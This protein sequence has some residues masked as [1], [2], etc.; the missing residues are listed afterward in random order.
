MSCDSGSF[1]SLL[2]QIVFLTLC[3]GCHPIAS[4]QSWE[5]SSPSGLHET[6]GAEEAFLYCWMVVGVLSPNVV[7]TDTM[8]G[9]LCYQW[10]MR[11][12]LTLHQEILLIPV[13]MGKMGIPC[14]RQVDVEGLTHSLAQCGRGLVIAW[15]SSWLSTP[16]GGVGMPHYNCARMKVQTSHFTS[17]Y[18]C[19]HGWWWGHSIFCHIWLD[20][21][22]IV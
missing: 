9:C 10:V 1:S 13:P 19:Q 16:G 5:S 2:V 22:V 11:K 20:Y 7:S 3:C 14:Y 17:A 18:V 12:V 4:H 21:S 6:Q 8:V 15:V